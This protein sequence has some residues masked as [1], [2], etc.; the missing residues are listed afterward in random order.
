MYTLNDS[1]RQ[2]SEVKKEVMVEEQHEHE[3]AL[4]EVSQRLLM[5]TECV[6]ETGTELSVS[7]G[8]KFRVTSQVVGVWEHKQQSTFTVS[9]HLE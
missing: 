4:F 6:V 7:Y 8:K 1:K 9:A 2:T 3:T 5:R